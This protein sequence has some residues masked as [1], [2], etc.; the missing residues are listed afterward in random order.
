MTENLSFPTP[1]HPGNPKTDSGRFCG[2][3]R[4]PFPNTQIGVLGLLTVWCLLW[5]HRGFAQVKLLMDPLPSVLDSDLDT[6]PIFNLQ[7]ILVLVSTI[8]LVGFLDHIKTKSS[9]HQWYLC[10]IQIQ[11]DQCLTFLP[12]AFMCSTLKT[13][14]IVCTSFLKFFSSYFFIV[15]RKMSFIVYYWSLLY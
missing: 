5:F 12:H 7:L 13:W 14:A 1:L 10:L 2:D 6:K 4:L 8:L 15:T 3:L 11:C 9:V